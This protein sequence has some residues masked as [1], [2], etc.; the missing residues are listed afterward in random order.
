VA[1]VIMLVLSSALSGSGDAVGDGAGGDDHSA[2]LAAQLQAQERVQ[3]RGVHVLCSRARCSTLVQ[4]PSPSPT[5]PKALC[6][7][8][9]QNETY[10]VSVAEL[11]AMN[12]TVARAVASRC[13]AATPCAV[14]EAPVCAAISQASGGFFG[15]RAVAPGMV[16]AFSWGGWCTDTSYDPDTPWVCPPSPWAAC[17]AAPCWQRGGEVL[18]ECIWH[19]SSWL[20]FGGAESGCKQMMST[21]PGTFDM[22]VLAGSEYV[23]GACKAVWLPR[24]MHTDT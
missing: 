15:G 19:N 21:V 8:I 1:V 9:V 4:P 18:C 20:D 13:T 11:A 10:E 23:L 6:R 14:G 16:S 7:C 24:R 12:A 3:C 2:A 17:M 22:R 5:R